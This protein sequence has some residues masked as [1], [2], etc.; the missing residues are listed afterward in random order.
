M[1]GGLSEDPSHSLRPQ[2]GMGRQRLDAKVWCKQLVLEDGGVGGAKMQQG[3]AW[4]T[5][6]FHCSLRSDHKALTFL[7][8]REKKKIRLHEKTHDARL[9][10]P[11]LRGFALR[12]LFD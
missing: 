11:I 8:M 6:V 3:S 2:F 12:V 7:S 10:L 5:T 9:V 4:Q 1:G